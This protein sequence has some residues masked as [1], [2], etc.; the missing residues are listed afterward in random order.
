MKAKL[1]GNQCIE[2]KKTHEKCAGT[3]CAKADI[4]E[5]VCRMFGI[6]PVRNRKNR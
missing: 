2:C 4:S 1:R 6:R 3:S 5:H